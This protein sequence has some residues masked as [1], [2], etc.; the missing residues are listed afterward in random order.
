MMLTTKGRYAVMAMVDIGLHSKGKAVS[1][2]DI[3]LRQHIALN[4]LE[5]IFSKLK[6]EGLVTSLRGPGGGY[7]LS[8]EAGS[9]TIAEVILAADESL[10]ITRCNEAGQSGCMHNKIRCLTHDLW[11]GLG[12]H[13][14]SYL[15]G[16]SLADVCAR[17]ARQDGVHEYIS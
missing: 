6:K 14:Y 15:K 8:R 13:I 10:K 9:I 7:L 12:D 4:Y 3:A 16:I 5:Q 2:Q 11:E 17:N 1:L